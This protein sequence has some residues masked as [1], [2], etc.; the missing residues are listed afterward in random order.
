MVRRCRSPKIS[1]RLVSSVLA[2]SRS[3]DEAV[4]SGT[5]RQNLRNVDICVCQRGVERCRGLIGSV[6]DEEPEFGGPVIKIH[7]KVT[8]LLRELLH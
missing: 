1:I 5:A 7:Q 2:V 4:R 3:L 8:G 6:A